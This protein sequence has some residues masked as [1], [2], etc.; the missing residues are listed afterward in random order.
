MFMHHLH[1]LS[2]DLFLCP[3]L[4]PSCIL[5]RMASWVRSLFWKEPCFFSTHLYSSL[6][7]CRILRKRALCVQF[8]E[9]TQSYYSTNRGRPIALTFVTWLIH[10]WHDSFMCARTHSYM[11]R[12]IHVWHDSF[13]CDMTHSYMTCLIHMWHDSFICDMTHLR[14]TILS[15][16]IWLIHMWHDSFICDGT[17]LCVTWL[18]YMWHDFHMWYDSFMCEALWHDA[19]MWDTTHSCVTWLIYM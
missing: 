18:I 13:L 11:T 9:P 10:L 17:H 15:C 6:P 3:S 14:V 19:S 4:P 2:E 12:L 1:S 16:V 7:P 8:R 5:S